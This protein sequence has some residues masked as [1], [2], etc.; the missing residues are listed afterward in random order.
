M[1]LLIKN[2]KVVDAANRRN[3]PWDVLVEGGVI[4]RIGRKITDLKA[5][6]IDA[7]GLI[8]CPGFIDMHVHLREPG[9][10]EKET[11]DTGTQAAAAGGFTGVVCMANTDPVNDSEAVTHY[12]LERARHSGITRVFP[13]GAITKG[14]KGESLAAL[15]EMVRGGVVAISDDGFS[16]PNA[17]LMRRAM[18]YCLALDIPILEHCENPELSGDG[19]M[20][21]GP[22]S[23]RLGLRGLPAI[24]EELQVARNVLL[25]ELTGCHLHVQHISTRG[26]V[27][28]VRTAKA[29][30]VR[31]SAEAT[32][33]HLTLTEDCIEEHV[34]D[35]NY[36]MNP[37]L[38]KMEDVS[39]L[40]Q[41]LADGTIDCIA[42]DH[43]PHG[44]DEKSQ[45]FEVAPFGII[46]LE[47]AVS[48]VLHELVATRKLSLT[49][50][51]EVQSLNPAK[52]L[53]LP[54]GTLSEGAPADVTLL[55]LKRPVV[56]R[57]ATFKS[58][59]R[60]TP[61]EG[62]NLQGGAVMTIVGGKIVW[63]A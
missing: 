55:N 13:C 48:V 23:T 56:V 62:M 35:T 40:R 17:Q 41:G 19:V 18:E 59:C 1:K 33:H 46:G 6:V 22:I 15:G 53:N 61:F 32:P 8:V 10:E 51:V 57:K 14:L 30:G 50:Y 45:E 28:I 47:T 27:E 16:V 21:E 37:P 4:A 54:Y 2:G 42:S 9:R 38:R 43:A 25:A 29:R 52:I 60:N 63:K 26:A 3:G 7:T 58:K 39:A 5:R 31:V 20:N 44:L 11:I 34:Y 12:I 36:K 24:A 49:R